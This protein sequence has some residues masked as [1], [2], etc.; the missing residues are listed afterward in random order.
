MRA[1]ARAAERRR[2]VPNALFVVS[3]VESLPTDLEAVADHV[4]V[5]FPW[6]SLLRG[7]SEP[8]GRVLSEI[9][10]ISAAGASIRVMWSVTPRDGVDAGDPSVVEEAF[11]LSGFDVQEARIAMLEEIEETRSSGRSDSAP[12]TIGLRTSC[13]RH[14][15]DGP[16]R[17]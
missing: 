1:S 16:T 11:R 3:S 15:K 4:F 14:G 8:H 6:G 2:A 17:R 12:A 10:R 7:L 5:T 13:V 9:G